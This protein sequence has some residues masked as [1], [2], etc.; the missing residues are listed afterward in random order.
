MTDIFDINEEME[1]EQ[2]ISA[3][4]DRQLLEFTARQVYSVQRLCPVHGERISE[5]EKA[6]K[7][8][9]KRLGITGTISGTIVGAVIGLV[10]YFAKR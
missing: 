10:D 1:F 5:L 9:K 2:H 6:D 3:M 4:N 7:N 8:D